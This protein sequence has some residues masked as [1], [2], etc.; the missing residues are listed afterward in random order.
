MSVAESIYT[1]RHEV[2]ASGYQFVEAPRVDEH[3]A[4]YYSDLTAG[5]VY[6]RSA[7]GAIQRFLPDRKWI[8]GIV[9]NADGAVLCSGRG[10]IV[11]L[12]VATGDSR[13]VLVQIR[14][15]AID[16]VNDIEADAR[17]ALYGGTIDFT[18]ILER[19]APPVP[20]VFFRI[21]PTG[22]VRVIR[23]DVVAS[24]GIAF[25]PDGSLLYHAESTRGVWVY[26]I[27]GAGQPRNPTMFAEIADCDGV[28][29]DSEA[30]LWVARWQAG[31]IV[32]Y[33][34]DGTV[35][36]RLKLPYP[37]VVSLTFGGADLCDLIVTTGGE[38]GATRHGA[39]LRVRCDVPG[40]AAQKARLQ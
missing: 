5:G 39:V 33:R 19:G 20:G 12:D 30:A 4:V 28:A 40:V 2:L 15:A 38:P 6:R 13:P 16:A 11:R 18:S 23:D 32:R 34:A 26:D 24:N 17:G 1:P 10:G 29:V 31:E 7:D 36:R 22:E 25:S 8:G 37:Y 35:N 27:D 21:E 3:G 14:N 9:F